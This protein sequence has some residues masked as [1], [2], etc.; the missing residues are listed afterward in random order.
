MVGTASG[1][2]LGLGVYLRAAGCD[3][4]PGPVTRGMKGVPRGDPSGGGGKQGLD[5]V[6]QTLLHPA[7]SAAASAR[8]RSHWERDLP[9]ARAAAL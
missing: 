6:I 4:T 5:Q 9:A 3:L 8:S 7:S 1:S 2:G